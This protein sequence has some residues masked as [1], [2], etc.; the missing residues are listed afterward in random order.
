MSSSD[1]RALAH[2]D[3][4]DAATPE[5][6]LR[7]LVLARRRALLHVADVANRLEMMAKDPGP[8]DGARATA[9]EVPERA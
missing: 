5:G 2:L 6:A 7:E 4:D 1:P 9:D 3:R 8:L